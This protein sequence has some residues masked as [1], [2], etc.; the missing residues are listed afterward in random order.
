MLRLAFLLAIG[1]FVL[2]ACGSGNDSTAT[3]GS[4]PTPSVHA[5][6]G[7]ET[8][9]P[10]FDNAPTL[11]FGAS[12]QALRVETA[13]TAEEQHLGLMNRTCLGDDWGMI[14]VYTTDVSDTFWMKNTFVPLTVA[15]VASD[16][17]IL[18]L[19]NMQPQTE[20]LHASPSPYRWAIEA[21]EGWYTAHGI[22]VGDRVS[23]P[24]L[25][26]S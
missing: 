9:A 6:C 15:F 5:P 14:F 20:E 3:P 22:R 26:L 4:S 21:N 7:S 1:V 10:A 17:T 11:T 24:P 25:L 13:S 23:I 12:S 2:A 18:A 19:I 16:G 8:P